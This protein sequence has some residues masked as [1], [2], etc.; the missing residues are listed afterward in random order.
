MKD[1]Q[2]INYR[3]HQLGK[4]DRLANEFKPCLQ[5]VDSKGNKTNF[6]DISYG[7]LNQIVR[8]LTSEKGE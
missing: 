2:T 7:E 8:I 5:I 3:Y 4:L 1:A 6:M